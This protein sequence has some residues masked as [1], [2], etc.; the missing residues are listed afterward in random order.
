MQVREVGM[1]RDDVL[2]AI[3]V[4]DD[5]LREDLA[6]AAMWRAIDAARARRRGAWMLCAMFG[7]MGLVL[8]V[9]FIPAVFCA[10][11]ALRA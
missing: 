6:R 3:R 9:F 11:E 1:D 4:R 8:P 2:Y 5:L 10:V 7:L